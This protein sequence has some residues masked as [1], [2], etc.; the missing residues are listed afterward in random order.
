PFK[1]VMSHQKLMENAM[2]DDFIAVKIG[3]VDGSARTSATQKNTSNR[4]KGLRLEF[5]ERNITKG[6]LIE[7][8]IM[9]QNFN[10]VFGFQFGLQTKGLEIIDVEGR[11]I[12]LT[13]DQFARIDKNSLRM[14]WSSYTAQSIRPENTIMILRLKAEQSGKLS[15]M[16]SIDNSFLNSEAYTG[17]DI[18]PTDIQISVAGAKDLSPVLHQNTPNPWRGETTIGFDLPESGSVKLTVSD[19]TGKIIMNRTI[20]GIKGANRIILNKGE[21]GL[22]SG[23]LMYKIEYGGQTFVKKM[24]L[25]E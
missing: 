22:S 1:E 5:E 19:I 14:S 8:P 11:G 2:N 4:T 25:V 3:D 15:E 23:V 10:E 6:E 12:D 17:S 9:S 13:K 21:M 7:L 16:I 18:T 20:Q 24:I